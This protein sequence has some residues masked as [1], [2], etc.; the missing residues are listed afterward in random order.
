MI[1]PLDYWN[2]NGS[3][4]KRL[5]KARKQSTDKESVFVGR[6]FPVLSR[7]MLAFQ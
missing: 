5:L 6:N 4:L 2:Q 3:K 1:I 7:T